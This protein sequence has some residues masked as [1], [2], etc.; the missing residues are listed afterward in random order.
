MVN[1]ILHKPWEDDRNIIF[2]TENTEDAWMSVCYAVEFWLKHH[3]GIVFAQVYEKPAYGQS[4][5]RNILPLLKQIVVSELMELR[6]D[7]IRYLELDDNLISIH[8][9]EGSRLAFV[10]YAMRQL[11]PGILVFKPGKNTY[12]SFMIQWYRS[13]RWICASPVPVFLIPEKMNNNPLNRVLFLSGRD[14]FAF[15]RIKR[16]SNITAKISDAIIDFY[17]VASPV[18][19]PRAWKAY[20]SKLFEN[21]VLQ[22]GK[23]DQVTIPHLRKLSDRL[24]SYDL[25]MIDRELIGPVFRNGLYLRKWMENGRSIPLL[26][27]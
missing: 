26:I 1:D 22:F 8:P 14:M 17:V 25:V 18:Q 16:F 21:S 10:H 23:L 5:I 4:L 7:I 3:Q 11:N 20:V 2:L 24:I 13:L 19:K 12:R 9:F 15:D 6:K 27:C